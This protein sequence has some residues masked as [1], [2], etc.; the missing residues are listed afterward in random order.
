MAAATIFLSGS[1]TMPHRRVAGCT[2][3]KFCPLWRTWV[4]GSRSIARTSTHIGVSGR[5]RRTEV[6]DIGCG[7]IL[8]A[9][10]NVEKSLVTRRIFYAVCGALSEWMLQRGGGPHRVGRGRSPLRVPDG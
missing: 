4:S 3:A 5:E 9:S 10:A 6:D 8:N 2:A 7:C 1:P